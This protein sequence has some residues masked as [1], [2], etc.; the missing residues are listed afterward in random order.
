V[1]EILGINNPQPV[2]FSNLKSTPKGKKCIY[3][4][5]SYLNKVLDLLE[6]LAVFWSNEL[7]GT[8]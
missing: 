2:D 7:K 3:S 5:F 6:N 4:W 1:L 8:L